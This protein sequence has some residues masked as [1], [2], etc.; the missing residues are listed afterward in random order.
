MKHFYFFFIGLFLTNF[1][2][3]GQK[4]NSNYTNLVQKSGIVY[5]LRRVKVNHPNRVKVSR[6]RRAKVNH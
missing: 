1:N 2:L 3:F 5:H 6:L 4:A